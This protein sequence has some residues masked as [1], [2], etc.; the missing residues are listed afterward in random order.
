MQLVRSLPVES[1]EL[2]RDMEKRSPAELE[3]LLID[4]GAETV[5]SESKTGL[6]KQLAELLS[7]QARAQ[8]GNYSKVS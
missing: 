1:V 8:R 3:A 2:L 5:C 7:E 4:Y 6:L